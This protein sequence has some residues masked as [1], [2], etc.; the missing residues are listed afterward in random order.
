[1]L[2]FMTVVSR[3]TKSGKEVAP[4]FILKN[5]KDL[6]IRGGDF[7]AIWDEERKMW[8]TDEQD[9][10]RLVDKT[11]DEF[12]ANHPETD[13]AAI[14]YMWDSDTGT[15]DKF[16]KYCQKQM[17]DNYQTLDDELIFMNT[18]LTRE[19]YASKCLNYPLEK[20]SITAYDRLISTL[21]APEER[22]KIEWAIGAIVSGDSKQIQKFMVLYGAAG[23]GKSTIL[24]I[25]QQ[26]FEG[27]YCVFDAKALGSN[28]NSFA[29]EQFSGNPLVAIQ[30]DGDLSKIEDNT[31]LNSMV[32]HEYMPVNEKFKRTYTSRFK[33]FLIM[34]TN[35]PVKITDGK[36]GLLRRLI[37]VNPSGNKLDPNEYEMIMNQIPFELGAIAYHCLQ[38]YKSNPGR[39]NGYVPTMMMDATNDFYNY[40]VDSY[41]VF[42]KEDGTTLKAAWEMYKTYCDDAKVAYPFNRRLFKEE[43]KNYFWDYDENFEDDDGG[44]VKCWFSGFKTDSI[45]RK[46]TEKKVEPKTSWIEFKEQESIFDKEYSDYPAQLATDSGIPMNKWDAVKTIL[47]D[48]LTSSLHYVRVPLQHI[49][50]DF[51]LKDENGNKSYEK[52]LEAA[53]K[54]PMTY[55]ELSKSGA[56]IH[57]HYIYNGDVEKLSR[58]FDDD[59][60]VKVFNGNSSLRR[61]LTKCNDLPIATIS[62][63]LPLKEDN[64]LISFDGIK[65]EK[66]LR[67]MIKRNLNKE[68][69]AAT[70]PS[71]DLIFKHLEDSYNSGLKYDVT[72][73]RN[74]VYSFASDSTNQADYCIK[75]VSKMKFKSDEPSDNVEYGEPPIVFYDIEVFPNLFM[76]CWMFDRD[77]AP[78]V[79]MINPKPSDI[80][81]LCKFRLIG[82]NN[83]D[84]DNHMLYACMLGY[85]NEQLYRLSKRLISKDKQEKRKAK[86][87]QAYNLSYTDIYDFASAGNKKSL[88]KLQIEMGIHHQELGY[89]W[90]KPVPEDKWSV[91]A[92]YCKNDVTSTRA[93][94]Y[95]LK[96]DWTARQIL[97]SITGMTVNDTTN[98]LSQRIIFG[99]DRAPQSQFNYR[100]LAEPV[101]SDRYYEYREKFGPDYNFRVFN[102]EGLPEY[103]DYIPGEELPDGWSIL[104]FF[105][106]YVFDGTKKADKSIYLGESIGEGGRVYAE[107][108]MYGDVWD[109]DVTGQHPSSIIAEV[110]FG[111]KYTKAFADIVYGRVSIKHQAW[112]DIDEL[113]EGKLKPFI[114]Q[115]LDGKLS[116]KDLANALKTVVNSVYGQTKA[117]YDC[118]FKDPR[119]KDNIVAKR[120]A[121]FMTL[122]K[123][124]VQKRGFTVAHIK[125]DSIKIPDATPAIQKFVEDFGKEFGYSFETE[126]E[127]EKFCLVN[128]AVY[129]AKT[130][131]GEW[132][133][134]GK[135]FAVPYV[136]KTLFSKEPIEMQDMCETF[137]AETAIY[138]D[139]NESLPDVSGYEK[140]IDKLE[141]QY[142]KGKISD[143][144]F[145]SECARLNDLIA[146][147]HNYRFV[148]RTGQFCPVKDGFGGGVLLRDQDGKYN[149][150]N[151]TTGYRWIESELIMKSIEDT[152]TILDEDTGEKKEIHKAIL[153][154]GNTDDIIDKSY[155][156]KLVDD[157]LETIGKYGDAEWFISDDPYIGPAVTPDFMNIPEDAEEELPFD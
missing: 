138:L 106:G 38:V 143:T 137:S 126:A 123:R 25:M 78:V 77:D 147:G 19:K 82:F 57:L 76:V 134:T 102:A 73:M 135:Q 80:E 87:G 156:N 8:S 94:F 27:Y 53:S 62:S 108:G 125:T 101:G 100:D 79:T 120:G 110:L 111:V 146:A 151:N 49:V 148:G 97:A 23:T 154:Q 72:D 32:S 114:Q 122:L 45:T 28:S 99:N 96:G 133:A 6:M 7:Y 105:P 2:D 18:E 75:L 54:W 4:K 109:G 149:A 93:A 50:I 139:V 65:S 104:P 13:G 39:Y 1:M 157:A 140:E 142:K 5:S 16:H 129:I 52:N 95:Y 63:G 152:T 128:N 107:P 64:K 91:V 36:S 83:R 15:I 88:K 90:D 47:K 121:L 70:K 3:S 46:T 61:K 119:N 48:I 55:A 10:I 155:Y 145:E 41:R 141:D 89:D 59:I 153:L 11:I 60:E 14:K 84:Y 12:C 132:T 58:I 112:S 33:C 118:V 20:G 92:D 81:D 150:V 115:V 86:F 68:Y 69:H 85:S 24:N 67:M 51:D 37:D 113:F 29:L 42:K 9:A 117:T 131:D 26:L 44:K 130:K 144:Y 17:R 40:I 74:A 127:F 21:Y 31:K 124:E 136:F 66:M 116:A 71:I 34:G 43:L 30:H 103:R 22:Q 56:G 98:S 35:R